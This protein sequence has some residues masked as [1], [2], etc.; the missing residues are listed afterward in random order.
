MF[1]CPGRNYVALSLKILGFNTPFRHPNLAIFWLVLLL[2]SCTLLTSLTN[3]PQYFY[4]ILSSVRSL[5]LC[6]FRGTNDDVIRRQHLLSSDLSVN[7]TDNFTPTLLSLSVLDRS[8]SAL[9]DSHYVV[10]TSF[11]ISHNVV[12]TVYTNI[13]E[14]CIFFFFFF[15]NSC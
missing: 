11:I 9:Y 2:Q 5:G 8:Y 13:C 4:E 3:T 10:I 6:H 7:I 1:V 12:L 14:N 15:F